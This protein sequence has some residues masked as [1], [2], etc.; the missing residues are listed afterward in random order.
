MRLD[1]RALVCYADAGDGNLLLDASSA[2]LRC[3]GWSET[4]T[5]TMKRGSR[6][7]NHERQ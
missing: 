4:T 5:P 7:D 3:A 1:M 6:D 2:D